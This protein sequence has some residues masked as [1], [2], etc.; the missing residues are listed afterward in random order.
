M[1]YMSHLGQ[2]TSSMQ[3]GMSA[4]QISQR[5]SRTRGKVFDQQ[6][7]FAV[8][9]VLDVTGKEVLVTDY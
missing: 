9:N 8:H 3:T 1:N 6:S 4:W 2:Y 7:L 5:F